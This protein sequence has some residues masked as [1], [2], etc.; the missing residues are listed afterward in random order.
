MWGKYPPGKKKRPLRSIYL[1]LVYSKI[2]GIR[3]IG[4]APGKMAP[5]VED[6]AFG[7]ETGV[8]INKPQKYGLRCVR[9]NY[10]S[11]SEDADAS[12]KTTKDGLPLIGSG[13]KHTK[14]G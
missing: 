1:D 3:S 13:K 4:S 6:P 2:H 8:K 7:V 12:G 14:R 10:G 9:V 11:T 5:S